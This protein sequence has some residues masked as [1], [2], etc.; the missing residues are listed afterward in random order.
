MSDKP[1][2]DVVEIVVGKAKSGQ[3]VSVPVVADQKSALALRKLV[4][5]QKP[6]EIFDLGDKQIAF[7][8]AQRQMEADSL[9][10]ELEQ[11]AAE[12]LK[13]EE[14]LSRGQVMGEKLSQWVNTA[15]GRQREE[16][17]TQQMIAADKRQGG[18][19]GN[20]ESPKARRQRIESLKG[21][22]IDSNNLQDLGY[23]RQVLKGMA[24]EWSKDE[25]ESRTVQLNQ[26][27]R[28]INLAHEYA[29]GVA[30]SGEQFAT[31]M[32][33][34][35]IDNPMQQRKSS[36]LGERKALVKGFQQGWNKVNEKVVRDD[37]IGK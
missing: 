31:T 8:N 29:E 15:E 4:K 6:P 16:A 9:K 5:P 21:R 34:D 12:N 20:W 7:A 37:K 11:A 17:I 19:L 35:Q 13:N 23:G 22:V 25:K 27:L 26:D 24:R 32:I 1:S 18:L 33:P 28:E 14:A 2:V 3:E 30:R 36:S 10:Q